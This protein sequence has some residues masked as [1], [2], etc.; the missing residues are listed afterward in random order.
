MFKKT[1]TLA[2]LLFFIAFGSFCGPGEEAADETE[3][4]EMEEP[5][6]MEQD[7]HAVANLAPASGSNVQGTVTFHQTNGQ[8]QVVADVTGLTPG[9]HGFHVHEI[10]DCSAP[11]AT[12]AGDHFAPEGNPHGAPDAAQ[13]HAGDLGNIEVDESGNAHLEMTVD[14]ISLGQ[15]PNSILGRAVL[16]HADPDDLTSQPSGNAGA[17]VACGVIEAG[18][19]GAETMPGSL[20]EET[21][22]SPQ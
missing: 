11:D 8:V 6:A 14:Y 3:P 12:S 1:V 5:A 2:I 7:L 19:A 13:H 17:R 16:V 21:P 18:M 4:T 15:G 9:T 20:A 22:Q 10:G